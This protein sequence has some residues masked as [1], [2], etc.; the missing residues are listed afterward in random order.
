MM[1][2]EQFERYLRATAFIGRSPRSTR[3][4]NR[5][6]SLLAELVDVTGDR[7]IISDVT[8][9][10]DEQFLFSFGD[11]NAPGYVEIEVFIGRA[12]LYAENPQVFYCWSA[13]DS[14][15]KEALARL[16]PHLEP[17]KLEVFFKPRCTTDTTY[18]ISNAMGA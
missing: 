17:L 8:I 3:I 14:I 10:P 9:G 13:T 7:L 12:E 1:S 5:A 2:E 15:P 11:E 4:R 6:I 16:D 18:I